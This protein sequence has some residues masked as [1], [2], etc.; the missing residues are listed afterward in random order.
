[1]ELVGGGWRAASTE[2]IKVPKSASGE[3]RDVGSSFASGSREE[4]RSEGVRMARQAIFTNP[5][6]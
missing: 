6:N 5:F 3:R 1:M 4:S 2:M